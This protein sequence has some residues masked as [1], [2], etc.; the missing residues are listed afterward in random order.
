MSSKS[1][2]QR[3]Q[4]VARSRAAYGHLNFGQPPALAHARAGARPQ[5]WTLADPQRHARIAGLFPML[6]QVL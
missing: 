6:L 4:R 2:E 1:T 3:R 5:T